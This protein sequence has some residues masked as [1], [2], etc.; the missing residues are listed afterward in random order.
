MEGTAM[1]RLFAQVV[2][3]A[4]SAAVVVLLIWMIAVIAQEDPWYLAFLAGLYGFVGLLLWAVNE[5]FF[6]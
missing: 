6:S 5:V 4:F 2:L 1:K 3:G